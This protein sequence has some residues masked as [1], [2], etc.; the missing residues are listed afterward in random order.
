MKLILK[1][2]QGYSVESQGPTG[3]QCFIPTFSALDLATNDPLTNADN[4]VGDP[5]SPISGRT[6]F[7]AVYFPQTNQS[8]V[9]MSQGLLTFAKN[10]IVA[11]TKI[12]CKPTKIKVVGGPVL[13]GVTPTVEEEGGK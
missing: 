7:K 8:H 2:L 6:P 10:E 9:F 13:D 11:S 5:N 3:K 12:S 4:F 1:N